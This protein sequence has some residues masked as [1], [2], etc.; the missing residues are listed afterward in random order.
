MSFYPSPPRSSCSP[1]A[2]S[3][4]RSPP[5]SRRPTLA[6]ADSHTFSRVPPP[7]LIIPSPQNNFYNT[8]VRDGLPK[9]N[10]PLPS[11]SSSTSTS[12]SSSSTSTP[13]HNATSQ[14][15]LE[16]Q[17]LPSPLPPHHH[18]PLT[19]HTSR[20]RTSFNTSDLLAQ[21]GIPSFLPP[22]PRLTSQTSDNTFKA[23]YPPQQKSTNV[24]ISNNYFTP[25]VSDYLNMLDTTKNLSAQQRDAEMTFEERKF[26][27]YA[28]D[29]HCMLT[30][31]SCA[32]IDL[33]YVS[34][35][36]PVTTAA[37]PGLGSE[38]DS[39][40]S[41]LDTLLSLSYLTPFLD[42]PALTTTSGG[43]SPDLTFPN[44]ALV[45]PPLLDW[46]DSF[47]IPGMASLFTTPNHNNT[48]RDFGLGL[49]LN[50]PPTP[51][52]PTDSRQHSMPP[53]KKARTTSASNV[54]TGIRRNV[55]P[56]SLVPLDAPTQRRTYVTPSSTSR[57]EIPAAF[58]R[59][60]KA[61]SIEPEPEDDEE[62]VGGEGIDWKD[63]IEAKRRQ[64]TIAARKSRQ[65]KLEY[66]RN[67]EQL[68][69]RLQ[70]ENE[71]LRERA[72]AAEER[73]GC[74]QRCLQRR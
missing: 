14:Y 64:N 27:R 1:S 47:A 26:R 29:P 58:S 36:A 17:H 3:T 71:A 15:A 37:A 32:V 55:T 63:A 4:S 51:T 56:S 40:E 48:S 66:V 39:P 65:R 52:S 22:P 23:P 8:K 33:S 16:S 45:S 38:Y 60:R 42:T 57:K 13:H 50:V 73:E 53:T 69:T 61:M 25:L 6:A 62:F 9:L 74:C 2:P 68:V 59:K 21:H 19:P 18:A 54:P 7:N 24:V 46:S 70:N 30:Q 11:A 41:D 10:S 28:P 43:P 49:D 20:P 35:T 34:G 5:R 72:E 31:L 67:L 44:N 12:S